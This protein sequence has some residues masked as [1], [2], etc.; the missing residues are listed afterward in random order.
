V[1]K[2]VSLDEKKIYQDLWRLS[3]PVMIFMVFQTTLELVDLYWVGYLGTAA[4][5][6]LSMSN[7]LFWML[8]T[9]SDIITISTLAL[10]ARH[11]GAGDGKSIFAVARHSFW[12]ATSISVAV[13]ILIVAFSDSFISLYDVEPE[14]HEM[15]VLYLIVIGISMLFAYSGMAL[16]AVLQGVGDTRTPMVVLVITNVIN[17]VLDPILIFGLAGAPEL[18][19]LGAAVA[20]LLARVVGFF[21]I[22][23]IVVSGKISPSRLKIVGLF[24]LQFQIAYFKKIFEIGLPAFMQTLTRPLTGLV[25]MWLVAFFGTPAIAAFGIGQRILGLA[26][27]FLSGLTVGTSTMIGQ[28]LGAG[29]RDLTTKI[30]GKAMVL[31][32]AVQT[33]MTALC[34]FGAPLIVGLFSRD[35]AAI[36]LGASFLKIIS[37][38]MILMG[39]FH[40]IDAVFKGSGYTIPSMVSAL[41][42][43][44]AIKLPVAYL[45]ALPLNLGTDGIWWSV[46]ISVLVELLILLPWYRRGSW[47]RREIRISAPEPAE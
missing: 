8:F 39:P 23:Y 21:T 13:T 25:M 6:A 34:F 41:V 44:W 32:L 29:L 19:I 31:S 27:I 3:W 11:R 37:A 24:K 33:G 7:N 15:A 20:T 47:S 4:V 40:I 2:L 46:S 16:G 18:G 35:P 38:C 22:L 9:F 17:I 12:L 36:E 45:L 5:A 1:Q 30:I 14:V 26:F 28:S 42:A 10:T 43:N